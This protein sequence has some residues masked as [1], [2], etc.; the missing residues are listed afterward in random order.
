MS[1]TMWVPAKDLTVRSAVAP[2]VA[3]GMV[4][5]LPMDSPALKLR[6]VALGS[7]VPAGQARA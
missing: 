2:S 5:V 6:K 4:P 1:M 7:A 3:M